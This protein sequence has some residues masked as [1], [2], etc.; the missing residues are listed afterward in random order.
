MSRFV[1]LMFHCLS[2]SMSSFNQ[3]Q[4]NVIE[5]TH[6]INDMYDNPPIVYACLPNF[7]PQWKREHS[8]GFS[9]E[10]RDSRS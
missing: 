8:S 10:L 9:R 1:F 2:S 6:I 7:G 4:T 3:L 5:I